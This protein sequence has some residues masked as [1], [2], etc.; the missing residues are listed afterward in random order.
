MWDKIKQIFE[1]SATH[2]FN[3]PGAYD[4]NIEKAS[5]SLLFAHISFYIACGSILTLMY[6]D[7]ILGTMAA[8][9][10]AALYFVFYMLRKLNKA[11]I[12]LDDRSFDLSND[13]GN[14]DEN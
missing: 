4:N 9:T 1:F 5:V 7:I 6:K 3:L 13:E 11:K 8:I 2:G 14:K 10:F 12:D